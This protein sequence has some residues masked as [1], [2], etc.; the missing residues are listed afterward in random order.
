[1]LRL[2]GMKGLGTIL[3]MESSLRRPM[4]PSIPRKEDEADFVPSNAWGLIA[5]VQ[6]PISAESLQKGATRGSHG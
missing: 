6:V 5:A 3:T 1:M 2:P 4:Q